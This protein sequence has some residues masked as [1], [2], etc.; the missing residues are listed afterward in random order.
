MLEKMLNLMGKDKVMKLIEKF[1]DNRGIRELINGI[2]MMIEIILKNR[3]IP[4][5]CNSYLNE[6]RKMRSFLANRVKTSTL[7]ELKKIKSVYQSASLIAQDISV[8]SKNKSAEIAR[9]EC[10]KYGKASYDTRKSIMLLRKYLLV[11]ES[12]VSKC[13]FLI[14]KNEK[15]VP[16][17]K[18][19]K[20]SKYHKARCSRGCKPDSTQLGF[21]RYGTKSLRA[22]RLSY[23][24]IEA[25]PR[26]II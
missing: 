20:Y 25:V 9:T 18:R 12:L 15:D 8:K 19:T 13:G 14:V 17:P 26:A 16:Y 4:Y 22:G 24:A 5:G 2:E 3:R 11:T 10:G 6:V 23:R 7:I 1:I 21:G